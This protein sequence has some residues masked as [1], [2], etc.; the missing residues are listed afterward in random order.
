MKYLILPLLLFTLSIH[1]QHHHHEATEHL[2]IIDHVE[3]QPMIAQAVRIVEGLDFVGNPLPGESA[4]KILAL[5]QKAYTKASVQEIQ[6]LLDPFV[7]AFVDINPE[8]R[9]KVLAGPAMPVLIQ[10]GWV[11]FLVKVHNQANITAE[12]VPESPNAL[13]L[14]HRSTG[15]HRMQE[16]NYLSPGEV[17]NQFLEMAIYQGRPLRS[18]LSGLAVDYF[19]LQFYTKESGKKEIKL[20]FNVGQ[21]TQDIGFRNTID[22]LVDIKPAVKVIFHVIDH[23]GSPAM[24]SFVVTDGLDRVADTELPDYRV[25]RARSTHWLEGTDE[26]DFDLPAGKQLHGIFPLPARR[27]AAKDEYPDFFFQ[28]QVYRMSGEHIFLPP[29]NY[30]VNY[31]R[32]PE[33]L[34][35]YKNITVP[36]DVDEFEINFQLERWI[37]MKDL[38]WFSADHHIHAAGCSHYESPEEGVRPEDMWRQVLGEDLD[39]GNNL[40]WGPSWYHQKQYF[41]GSNHELSNDDNILR[42]DVEVSGFPSSHAGHIVLLNLEEDDYPN[43]TLIEEWPTW[44]LPVL[45]W[46]KGQG[47]ITGYAHSGWGL[48]PIERTL[49]LPN[50]ILPKMDGI[51]AN[52]YVVTVTHDAIDFYSAGDT[53]WPA[54]LNMWYHTLNCGYRVRISGE[55]DFPCISDERVGRA[56]IYAELD[57]GLDFED[58][59]D[60]L[61]AGRSYVSEG[62]A[63][64]IDFSVNAQRLGDNQSELNIQEGS[65]IEINAKASAYLPVEQDEIGSI[66]AKLNP[67]QS[68]YWHIERS[69]KGQTRLVTIELVV[70][71]ELVQSQDIEA[72]GSWHDVSFNY[73]LIESSWIA[74]RV[75]GSAHTNPIF[76]LVNEEPILVKK[77]A[78][79]CRAAV[80]QCWEMK[81]GQFR[82]EEVPDAQEGYDHAREVYDRMIQSKD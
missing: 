45:Q 6:E 64:L 76:A 28:P 60:A 44:T 39:M 9:V 77:S 14:L 18:N 27:L 33:Y 69:R 52:E 7:I 16:K 82:T 15:A 13:P 78:E 17:D 32:G 3:P 74:L 71:G 55:T 70:N 42:Y 53:P 50:Y 40:T 73:E 51:G 57:K 36:A 67:Y 41:T 4:D 12:L 66:I 37:N 8:S 1:A 24:A 62:H 26:R 23:D 38:G 30:H 80:D 20:G 63:H 10:E 56:R 58:Y 81:H 46:A 19:L 35:L 59:M 75:H 79:W 48:A 34:E 11:T 21:G 22:L 29:G 54:E 47:G 31:G 72:N 2:P 5:Q 43:T 25:V 61:L 68:P 65:T 49:E